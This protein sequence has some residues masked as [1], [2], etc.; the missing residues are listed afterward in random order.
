[1]KY[2][3]SQEGQETCK[4]TTGKLTSLLLK[5]LFSYFHETLE[6][7]ER[8]EVQNFLTEETFLSFHI[9]K[10]IHDSVFSSTVS[11]ICFQA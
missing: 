2:R 8:F 1:M 10:D 3:D 11:D 4:C 6:T 7:T 9:L 5:S